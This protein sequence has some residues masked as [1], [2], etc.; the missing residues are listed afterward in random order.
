MSSRV[1]HV[2]NLLPHVGVSC[3]RT[4]T[5]QTLPCLLCQPALLRAQ[6]AASVH[7]TGSITYLSGS[8]V[9]FRPSH[10]QLAPHEHNKGKKFCKRRDAGTVQLNSCREASQSRRILHCAPKV[11]HV[12]SLV[13]ICSSTSG[14]F[15]SDSATF[16]RHFS[17]FA[18]VFP[19]SASFLLFFRISHFFLSFE[20][21]LH[22]DETKPDT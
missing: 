12:S 1:S 14:F 7:T 11:F 9:R 16:I 5:C 20:L 17:H 21:S 4:T 6:T 13:F 18:C 10:D 22:F 2:L 3:F 15:T 19:R 8:I